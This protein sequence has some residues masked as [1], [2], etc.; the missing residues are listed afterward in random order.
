MTI[1]R[2]PHCLRIDA[3]AGAL[4]GCPACAALVRQGS[5]WWDLL[6]LAQPSKG[7]P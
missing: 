1:E 6:H 2:C 5:R 7:S 3:R 4:W